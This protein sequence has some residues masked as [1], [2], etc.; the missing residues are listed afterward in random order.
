[1]TCQGSQLQSGRAG[2]RTYNFETC[3]LCMARHRRQQGF[4]SFTS[5]LPTKHLNRKDAS[6]GQ[7][8]DGHLTVENS[9]VSLVAHYSGRGVHSFLRGQL[10]KCKAP[11]A[12]LPTLLVDGSPT[13][14]SVLRRTCLLREKLTDCPRNVL[15]WCWAAD[16]PDNFGDISRREEHL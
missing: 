13:K 8:P 1:M 11:L 16:S 15:G 14:A 12:T 10:Q 7:E 5:P 6:V 4:F 9:G 2:I 3:A